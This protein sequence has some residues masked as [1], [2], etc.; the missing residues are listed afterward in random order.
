MS[1][2]IDNRIKTIFHLTDEEFTIIE[3]HLQDDDCIDES[4][5]KTVENF[6][7]DMYER[8]REVFDPFIIEN[9]KKFEQHLDDPDIS[10]MET[11]IFVVS[12]G[13][14]TLDDFVVLTQDTKDSMEA[15]TMIFIYRDYIFDDNE[16][17]IDNV[18]NPAEFYKY[19]TKNNLTISTEMQ[20]IGKDL[21]EWLEENGLDEEFGSFGIPILQPGAEEYIEN[22]HK[23]RGGLFLNP[24]FFLNVYG[25][26][27][28]KTQDAEM[29]N[30]IIDNFVEIAEKE[31]I[32]IR[33]YD[34]F[35][36]RLD[37]IVEDKYSD[38][39]QEDGS[40]TVAFKSKDN[41]G[42]M[43]KQVPERLHKGIITLTTQD[44]YSTMPSII[45]SSFDINYDNHTVTWENP[46]VAV[47]LMHRSII[48]DT[49]FAGIV[50]RVFNEDATV[51]IINTQ[52]D[53]VTVP[54]KYVGSWYISGDTFSGVSDTEI[55]DASNTDINSGELLVPEEGVDYFTTQKFNFSRIYG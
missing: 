13:I 4:W 20:R 50:L 24:E 26:D 8:L 47:S 19:F 23:K 37:A 12:Q 44:A 54:R 48:G 41:L 31:D 17:V 10:E 53:T 6:E 40:L 32:T 51:E 46:G 9:D 30:M 28:E 27:I 15:N 2:F 25:L 5:M 52:G 36:G 45:S 39:I 14:G 38:K 7:D 35:I 42:R 33:N 11:I 22:V 21:D 43:M 18:M 3:N 34:S 29:I 55:A 49:G 16:N 1:A